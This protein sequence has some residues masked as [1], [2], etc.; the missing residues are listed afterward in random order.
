MKTEKDS[1][2]KQKSRQCVDCKL[3][4]DIE[5]FRWKNKEK[6]IR[7]A[8]CREC[9]KKYRARY[10]Q[11]NKTNLKQRWKKSEKNRAEKVR[12]GL[13]KEAS[14]KTCKMCGE[15][16]PIS[17]FRWHQKD[18]LRRYPYCSQCDPKY[19]ASFYNAEADKKSKYKQFAKLRKVVEQNKQKPCADCG[20]QY[21]Y[22]VMD[23]DHIDPSNKTAKVSAMVY[24]GSMPLLL[25]EIEK[26]EVVCANCHRI[27]T[28]NRNYTRKKKGEASN[29]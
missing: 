7:I 4:K 26:C 24:A 5:E 3:E 11:E 10:Y 16:K 2:S 19:R 6:G 17:D 8:R 15:I 27:R 22:Y 23:Y 13:I 18:K 1:I 29:E 21:P 20:I 9:D 28:H 25:D 12:Q 14:E